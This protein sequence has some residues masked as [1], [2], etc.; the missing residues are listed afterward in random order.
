MDT[1]T[2]KILAWL[3]QK[4]GD[5][6]ISPYE[7]NT[8]TTDI[9]FHLAECNESRDK[10]V[11][12][13]IEDLKLKTKETEA[14]ANYLKELLLDTVG[15]SF[16]SLT[17]SGSSYMNELVE[18]ALLLEIK[19]TSLESYV[20]AFNELTS[21][22]VEVETKNQ[23]MNAELANQKTKF[24]AA[25]KLE[26]TLKEDLAKAEHECAS[27]HDQVA[28]R[29]SFLPFLT[30]KNDEMKSRIRIAETILNDRK[31]EYPLVTHQ[32]LEDLSKKLESLQAESVPM[33]EKLESFLDLSPAAIEAEFEE[34]IEVMRS[35]EHKQVKW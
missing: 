10:D 1:Q 16:T 23:E 7:V 26:K 34:K 5:K 21:K 18:S 24:T 28:S 31:R 11:S 2:P 9:L 14:T 19:D 33:R 8:Q 20:L 29:I 4:L 17:R 15:P 13:V 25:L 3:K 30:K 22:L 32:S 12:L 6:P 27:Q 35:T